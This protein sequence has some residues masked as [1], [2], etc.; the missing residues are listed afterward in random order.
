MAYDESVAQNIRVTLEKRV[1][2]QVELSE[3]KMFGGLAFML[4]DHMVCGVLGARLMARVGPSA[5]AQFLAPPEVTP[6]DFTG[7]PLS[8]YLYVD[9]QQIAQA[10][11][12][13]T[14]VDR[15]VSF[16]STLPPKRR[17]EGPPKP[18]PRKVKTKR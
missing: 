6:M 2:P 4:G 13:A 15:C 14:W 5:V 9:G 18:R 12:L 16:V 3:R 11:K 8:G 7:R 10:D 17:R 1:G